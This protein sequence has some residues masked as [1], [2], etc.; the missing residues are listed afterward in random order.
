M[1]LEGRR[2]LGLLTVRVIA[3]RNLPAADRNGFSDPYIEVRPARRPARRHAS[4]SPTPV[5]PCVEVRRAGGPS[6]RMHSLP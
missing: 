2:R 5:F 3:A 4:P 1:W 6:P